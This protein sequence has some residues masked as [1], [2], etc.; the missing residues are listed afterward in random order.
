MDKGFKSAGIALLAGGLLMFT[1]MAPIF[2][3]LPDDM[4]FPPEST[5]EM[6]RLA[7]I[8][9]LRWQV[10]H[11]MGLAAVSLF[12]FAYFWHVSA[13]IRRGWKRIGL[14]V[15]IAATSAFGLFAIALS[16][17]G[18]LV[19]AA[20][21]RYLSAGAELTSLEQVAESHRLALAFF[22]PGVFLIFVTM[23]LVS[24]PM[25]HQILHARW[26]GVAGQTIAILA[27]VA[28]LTG[29]AGRH[30][31]KL[32]IAGTLMM[33]AFAWHLLVGVRAMLL[34]P[35]SPGVDDEGPRTGRA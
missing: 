26:L 3:V 29:V 8:A 22:T 6:I 9:G 23:G 33:A 11:V 16:I 13:L 15:G 30:W 27:I 10:S 21:Q 1:R 25:L 35:D 17:D 7:S 14:A 24:S 4:P 2:S 5:E 20:I 31:D 18:F 19:P 28:Y 34:K 32:Q 12:A